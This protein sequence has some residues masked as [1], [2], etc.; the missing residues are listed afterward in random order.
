MKDIKRLLGKKKLHTKNALDEKSIFY[1][2]GT[3]VKDDFGKQGVENIKPISFN[4]GTLNVWIASSAWRDVLLENRAE[5]KKKMNCQVE[6]EEIRD[7]L[8][9]G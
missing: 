8:I 6:S 1:L 9:Q 7:I 5:I 2:F 3:I 4:G